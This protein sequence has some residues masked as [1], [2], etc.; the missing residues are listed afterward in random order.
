MPIRNWCGSSMRWRSPGFLTSRWPL[1]SSSCTFVPR[2]PHGHLFPR[3][4]FHLVALHPLFYFRLI[5]GLDLIVSLLLFNHLL[6]FWIFSVPNSPFLLWTLSF[7][8]PPWLNFLIFSKRFFASQFTYNHLCKKVWSFFIPNN[9]S[10]P[11]IY[12]VC[13]V[14]SK[15]SKQTFLL[16][17]IPS[18]ILFDTLLITAHYHST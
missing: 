13:K 1:R 2:C 16:F 8:T 7:R 6:L 18:Q 9:C 10:Y 15:G 14:S 3:A 11:T 17:L 12:E 5:S 4:F